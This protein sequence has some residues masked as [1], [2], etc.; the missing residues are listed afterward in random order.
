MQQ[1]F[2]TQYPAFVGILFLYTED[3][4]DYRQLQHE[5]NRHKMTES[6][7]KKALKTWTYLIQL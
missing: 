5:I 6:F 3:F 4:I 1:P 2:L 7:V